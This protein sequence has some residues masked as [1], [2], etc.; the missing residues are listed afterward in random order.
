[1]FFSSLATPILGVADNQFAFLPITFVLSGI[2]VQAILLR[3][4]RSSQRRKLHLR[5]MRPK[6][7]AV[8]K[9]KVCRYCNRRISADA[10]ICQFCLTEADECSLSVAQVASQAEIQDLQLQNDRWRAATNANL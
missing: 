4:F 6:Q 10:K 1:M 2:I 9:T 8:V 7:T 5:T 3:R